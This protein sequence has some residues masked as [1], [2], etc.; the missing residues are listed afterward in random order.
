MK[1]RPVGAEFFDAEGQ[2][3]RYDEANSRFSQ[4][5][6]GAQSFRW[7]LYLSVCVMQQD[8]SPLLIKMDFL[9]AAIRELHLDR[10]SCLELF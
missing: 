5:C 6:D 7:Y 8:V 3:D 4:F 2:T 9:I 1:I 10:L